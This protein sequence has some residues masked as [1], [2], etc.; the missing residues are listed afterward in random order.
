M[1]KQDIDSMISEINSE[2]TLFAKKSYL[3]TI[4]FPEIIVGRERPAK[5]LVRFFLEHRQGH[6]VPFIS[7]YGRSGSGKSST[8]KFV[9]QNMDGISYR[10]VNLRKAKTVFGAANLILSELGG[11]ELK[12][13]QGLNGVIENIEGSIMELFEKEKK[14]LLVL[15]LDEYDIIFYDRRNNPSDFIFRLVILEQNLKEKGF[16]MC[17]IAIS[18]NALLE[19]E[20]DSRV[21][22]R[23]GNSEIFFEPYTKSA[24]FDILKE[25]ASKAFSKKIDEKVLQYCSELSSAEH[26][27]ARRA[28]DL[29]R[30]AAEI[31]SSKSEKLSQGHVD[32]AQASLDRDRIVLLLQYASVHMKNL[33]LGIARLAFLTGQD[34]QATST[35]YKQYQLITSKSVPPMESLSYR[36]ISALLTELENTGLVVS[37][38]SSRGRHGYGTSYKL[39]AS[40]SVI[41]NALGRDWWKDVVDAKAKHDDIYHDPRFRYMDDTKWKKIESEKYWREYIGIE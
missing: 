13:A 24:V 28:I 17:I 14:K 35:I 39:T 15:V 4:S 5:R 7:V 31:A 34:W 10:F 18:N 19:Y 8:V 40:P 12:S 1:K 20:L 2:D 36:R 26:G 6:V 30:V 16:L 23:I 22:S 9:C 3:D 27:D 41:G 29:L 25:R 38:T 11:P 32:L 33:S 37:Q 21:K